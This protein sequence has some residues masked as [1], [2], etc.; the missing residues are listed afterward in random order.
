MKQAVIPNDS[1]ESRENSGV[2]NIPFFK[3]M[4]Y[5]KTAN[6]IRF[7]LS[8]EMTVREKLNEFK[9][10]KNTKYGNYKAIHLYCSSIVRI[11]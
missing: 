6:K 11:V 7:L 4:E 5:L 1:E 3:K 10:G 8:V 9:T 2:L